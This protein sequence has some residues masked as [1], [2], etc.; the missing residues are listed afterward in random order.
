[1]FAATILPGQTVV[2]LT[3]EAI[4]TKLAAMESARN[5]RLPSYK[6]TREYNLQL[7]ARN[8]SVNSIAEFEYRQLSGKTF[9]I[10]EENGAEG[11][12]RRALRK[13]MEAEVKVVVA[14]SEIEVS[15]NNYTVTIMGAEILNGRMCHVLSL[16]PKRNSKYLIKGKAWIDSTEFGVVRLEGHP[17]ESLSFWVGKPFISQTFSNVGGHWLLLSNNSSVEAKIVGHVELT[18]RSSNYTLKPVEHQGTSL[19]LAAFEQGK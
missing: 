1:M 8:K 4:L 3:A 13:L 17:T 2:P 12:Y 18:V 7:T 16:M 10:L 15:P 11:L 6:V 9:R 5:K 19:V 14:E